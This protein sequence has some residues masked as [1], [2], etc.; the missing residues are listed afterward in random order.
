[1]QHPKPDLH[2]YT[3]QTIYAMKSRLVRTFVTF[4]S[5]LIG[6]STFQSCIFGA[7]YGSPYAMFDVK[8]KVA[9][10]TGKPVTRAKVVIDE[11]NSWTDGEGV[12]RTNLEY[13]DTLFT[14][15]KGMIKTSAML[16]GGPDEVKI[17]IIDADG[18]ANGEFEDCLLENVPVERLKKGRGAWDNGTYGID[19]EAEVEVK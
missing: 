17:M 6:V 13:T 19:F 14:D 10:Q 1:M 9:G 15:S 11:Y 8:G 5:G 18:P 7:M 12:H 3:V 4:L 2:L 16:S